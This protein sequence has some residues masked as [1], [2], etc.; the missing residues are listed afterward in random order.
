[1][2]ALRL[3]LADQLTHHVSALE[4]I[5]AQADVILMAE[6]RSEATYVKHHKK[7]IAYLFSAMRHFAAELREQGYRVHYTQYNDEDNA[8]SLAAEV[9]QRL[10]QYDCTEVV[11]TFPGEY[12]VLADMQ[13]WAKRLDVPVDIRQDHRFIATIEDFASWAKG[14]KQLRMEFFYREMRKKLNSLMTLDGQPEGGK[15]NYDAQ[16]RKSLPKKITV[17]AHTQFAPD[18]ITEEVLELVAGEFDDHFGSLEHFHYGVTRKQALKVLEVFIAER[19]ADFGDYQDAMAQG[20]PWM[21]HSHIALYLNSGLLTPDEIVQAVEA[22]YHAGNAPLNAVEGFIRQVIGWREYVRGLYWLKMPG[23]E[24]ENF[25][26]ATRALPEFYWTAQTDMNCLRQCVQE[27]SDN[28]YAH[29][30]QRLM[31]LGNFALLA[32]IAPEE[33]N[34]WYLLVY[35]DAYEWVELPNVSGM[36]LFADGGVLASKPYAAS[37]AYINKMSNYCQQCKYDVKAKNGAGA[38]PFNYLYWDFLLRNREVLKGNHRMGMIY[39]TLNKM[40]DEKIQA[41]QQDSDVF[42]LKLENG[43]TV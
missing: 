41:V 32:G 13:S 4:G 20:E 18:A 37:G 16:N 33:V 21:F 29:H 25:L 14:K 9:E 2:S 38:C 43:D 27:T 40:S 8:G 19:L 17:P 10:K 22:E 31:V 28:A 34:N 26:N 7:K 6:V 15:W 11:T 35:A 36:V 30:I 3:I 23:Y 12:R 24:Q 39:N 1:M 5:D 42:F